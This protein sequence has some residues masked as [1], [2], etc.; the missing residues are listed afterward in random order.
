MSIITSKK[1]ILALLAVALLLRLGYWSFLGHPKYAADTPRYMECAQ[2]FASGDIK[3]VFARWPLYQL[4]PLFLSPIYIF[5]MH[6]EGY[7]KFLHIIFSVSTVFLLYYAGRL[8]LSHR[9]GLG[10]A[11]LAVFYPSFIFWLPYVMSETAFLFFL[12]LFIVTFLKLLKERTFLRWVSY[13]AAC[14]LLLVARP[15][16]LA[17]LA[18]STIAVG[19]LLIQ[20][21]F[22]LSLTRV[23]AGIVII[24]TIFLTVFIVL[25]LPYIGRFPVLLK[26]HQLVQNFYR[27]TTISSNSIDELMKALD[28]E[29][30]AVES[31]PE[32]YVPA[33]KVREA[34]KFISNHPSLYLRMSMKRFIAFWYPWI[35]AVRWSSFHLMLDFFISLSLTLGVLAVLFGR[36]EYRGLP[37]V[38]LIVMAF[39]LAVIAAFGHLETDAR[40]RLPAELILLLI[41]P[42]GLQILF[43]KICGLKKRGY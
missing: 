9:Y 35:F 42:H 23:F 5:N 15:V 12:A 2:T 19:T 29:K 16:S 17:I 7:L 28:E 40:L 10:V 25:S 36:S 34:V 14:A 31:I 20:R 22:N 32:A 4:Y 39:S 27:S 3:E 38:S 43:S 30:K 8:L 21:F 1:Y 6:E 24:L 33:Y 11:A 26:S 13:L 41:A 18:V 37:I